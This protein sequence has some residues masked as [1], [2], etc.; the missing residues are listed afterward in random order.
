MTEPED[1]AL[2]LQ[3]LRD[4][5]IETGRDC[6]S[7]VGDALAESIAKHAPTLSPGLVDAFRAEAIA[8]GVIRIRT[9][10]TALIADGVRPEIAE[11]FR[12]SAVSAALSRLSLA[13]VTTA[14]SGTA[15]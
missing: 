11:L 3:G 7:V 8:D 9:S 4:Q 6:G 5:A 12:I 1:E 2:A 13:A 10:E 14:A 15:N